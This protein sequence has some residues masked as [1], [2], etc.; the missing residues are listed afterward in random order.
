M[1]YTITISQQHVRARTLT[2]LKP[3]PTPVLYS[4]PPAASLRSSFSDV[5]LLGVALLLLLLPLPVSLLLLL[6]PLLLLAALPLPFFLASLAAFFAFFF[7]EASFTAA[8]GA[9]GS[10]RAA[11]LQEHWHIMRHQALC[12]KVLHATPLQKVPCNHM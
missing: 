11:V 3:D 10:C 2:S 7:S 4:P 1:A 5:F 12:P 8:C 6:L 9:L